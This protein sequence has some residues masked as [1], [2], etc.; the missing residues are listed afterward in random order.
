MHRVEYF[1]VPM[2]ISFLISQE[3]FTLERLYTPVLTRKGDSR[4]MHRLHTL[5]L[6]PS[7][8]Q[9]QLLF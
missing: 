5:L 2:Q 1:L 8:R 6:T 4:V 9:P 3:T 7:D